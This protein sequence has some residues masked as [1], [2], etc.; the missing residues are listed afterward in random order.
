[1]ARKHRARLYAKFR[2][3][4]SA[5]I[6][7][8]N[9][10]SASDQLSSM[11]NR[12]ISVYVADTDTSPFLAWAC[13]QQLHHGRPSAGIPIL[14]RGRGTPR[15]QT[16]QKKGESTHERT[17]KIAS[18]LGSIGQPRTGNF[19]GV[20]RQT[21]KALSLTQPDDSGRIA[22]SNPRRG[23]QSSLPIDHRPPGGRSCAK[24]TSCGEPRSHP[25]PQF[26]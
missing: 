11:I 15:Q 13:L 6:N 5:S 23:E 21:R 7:L 22:P 19:A 26:R 9:S 10:V 16:S 3:C 24:G 8:A 20:F 12:L 25:P 14:G 4:G 2:F 1:M 17:R 18:P